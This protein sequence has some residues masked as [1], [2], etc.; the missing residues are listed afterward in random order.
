MS[1][2]EWANALAITLNSDTTEQIVGGG[3]FTKCPEATYYWM[4]DDTGLYFYGD[5]TDST[6][7]RTVH[8]YGN[9]HYNSGD[10][11]QFCVYPNVYDSGYDNKTALF[12]WDLVIADNGLAACG[13]H[14]PYGVWD[15]M[16]NQWGT[17]MNE[18]TAVGQKDGSNYQIEAFFPAELWTVTDTPLYIEEGATFALANVLMEENSNGEQSLFVDTAWFHAPLSNK[19]TLVNTPAGIQPGGNDPENPDV[20]VVT[21]KV[22]DLNLDGLLD[23]NDAMLLFQ[24]SMLPDIFP[25]SY[26]GSID[27]NKDTVLDIN[28]AMLLF[29]HS[30]LPDI[31]PLA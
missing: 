15:H 6:A 23:I 2:G 3:D 13:E 31:F 7:P 18:V 21:E 24:H 12:F 30:M 20:P 4:W 27:F 8:T 11:I 1:E 16:N 10:G 25:L 9:G 28:D 22:G 14:F 5:V 26:K 29:Q 19:Y 17:H